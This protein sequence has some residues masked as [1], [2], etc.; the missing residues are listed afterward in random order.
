MTA[1]RDPA[2]VNRILGRRQRAVLRCL[3]EY[4]GWPRAANGG[5]WHYGGDAQTLRIIRSLG[6]L[7]LA[8]K[9]PTGAWLDDKKPCWTLSDAG[10][11][12]AAEHLS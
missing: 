9:H 3:H 5:G 12:W 11:A 4:G 1:P 2:K 10:K 7:G 6:M 8:V